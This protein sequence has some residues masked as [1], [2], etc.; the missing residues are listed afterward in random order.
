MIIHKPT[1]QVFKNRLEA[2]LFF[3][4]ANFHRLIRKHHSDFLFTENQTP[5]ANNE[6]LYTNTEPNKPADKQKW[7]NRSMLLQ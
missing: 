1:K 3:G 7:K 4:S 5:F 2:K 6:Y